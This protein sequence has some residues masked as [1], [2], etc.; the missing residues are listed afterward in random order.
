MRCGVRNHRGIILA[1]RSSR[2]SQHVRQIMHARPC[3][4]LIPVPIIMRKHTMIRLTSGGG[5]RESA[6][7]GVGRA[8]PESVA[9]IVHEDLMRQIRVTCCGQLPMDAGHA[10]AALCTPPLCG[11]PAPQLM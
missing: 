9:C 3:C 5:S 2:P 8:S 4:V 7:R 11:A 10:A 6:L 1:S